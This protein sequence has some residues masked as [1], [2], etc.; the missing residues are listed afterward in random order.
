MIFCHHATLHVII[1]FLTW[2]I[3]ISLGESLDV[4]A[5]DPGL[6]AHRLE[7]LDELA[8]NSAPFPENVVC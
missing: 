7:D 3:S 8:A 6:G 4:L 5:P 2:H 1:L